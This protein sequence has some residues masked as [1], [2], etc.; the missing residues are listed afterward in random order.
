MTIEYYHNESALLVGKEAIRRYILGGKGVVT[1]KSPSGVHHTYSFRF[2]RE[3]EKFPED[4]YFV[5]V[6]NSETD[7]D[8]IGM[9]QRGSLRTTC[10]SRYAHS[11]PLFKGA[12]YIVKMMTSDMDTPMMLYH[13]GVCSICGKR[14]TN[15]KSL[16]IGIGPVCLHRG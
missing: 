12:A 5:Y 14:L 9:L 13:E 7:W 11:N 4:T 15:P 1:L 6:M 16:E 3:P 10:M 8:Y 2:P